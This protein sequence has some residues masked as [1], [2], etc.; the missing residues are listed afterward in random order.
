MNISIGDFIPI[1]DGMEGTL[2]RQYRKIGKVIG[3]IIASEGI[4]AFMDQGLADRFDLANEIR[5][6]GL[7]AG[8]DAATAGLDNMSKMINQ[9]GFTFGDAAAFVDKFSFAVGQVGV[10]KALK[11]ANAMATRAFRDGVNMMQSLV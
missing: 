1:L 3:F 8:F 5:Q 10:E 11:F 4:N 7:M 2:T 6:S 9:T